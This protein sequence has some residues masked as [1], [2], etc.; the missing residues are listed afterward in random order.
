MRCKN[1]DIS[2]TLHQKAN[3]YKCH[4]CGFTRASTSNCIS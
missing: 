4:Y 3:A 1:C 2:L